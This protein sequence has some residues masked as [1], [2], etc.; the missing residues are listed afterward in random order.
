VRRFGLVVLSGCSLIL[1]QAPPD[2]PPRDVPVQC[3]DTYAAPIVDTVVGAGL[4]AF[5][6]WSI[7]QDSGRSCMGDC[8]PGALG[9]VAGAAAV[10]VA[11]PYVVGA[12]AGYSSVAR[13][14]DARLHG[15][16]RS[17]PGGD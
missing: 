11:L 8:G 10:L 14:V 2:H 9:S 6:V 4:A 16:S 3:T 17:R 13:C 1:V 7:A 12:I 5:G 15:P